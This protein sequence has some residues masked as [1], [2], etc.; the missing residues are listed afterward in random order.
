M[1][2][3]LCSQSGNS[4][5]GTEPITRCK[6]AQDG[7]AGRDIPPTVCT[8]GLQGAWVTERGRAEISPHSSP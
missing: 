2:T 6:A 1:E 7:H 8:P 3:L 4:W 5:P